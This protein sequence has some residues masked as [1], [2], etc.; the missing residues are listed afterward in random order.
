M[1][2]QMEDFLFFFLRLNNIPSYL[3]R[4][5]VFVHSSVDG[6]LGYFNIMAIVCSASVNNGM[7]ISL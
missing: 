5:H 4:G 7:Q 1:L 2:S 6:H 3:Y